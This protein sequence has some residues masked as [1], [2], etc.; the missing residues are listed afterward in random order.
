MSNV[1]RFLPN[2]E[3]NWGPKARHGRPLLGSSK[4]GHSL[5]VRFPLELAVSH[6]SPCQAVDSVPRISLAM[7]FFFTVCMSRVFLALW[8][9]LEH[10]I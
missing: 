3:E 1:P 9:S 10:V 5:S 8:L 7:S 2:P 6:A 4:A